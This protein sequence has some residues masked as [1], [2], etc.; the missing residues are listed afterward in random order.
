M[1]HNVWSLPLHISVANEN[2]T[3]INR[4]IES[5]FFYDQKWLTNSQNNNTIYL[6]SLRNKQRDIYEDMALGDAFLCEYY[7][8]VGK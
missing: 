1:P 6:T 8:Q 7:S 4:D 2:T 5:R 3:Q